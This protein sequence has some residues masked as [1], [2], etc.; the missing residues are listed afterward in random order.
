MVRWLR[1]LP[2]F[3]KLLI[4]FVTMI[5][6]VGA[7]GV[8]AIARELSARASAT[9]DADLHRASLDARGVLLA[10]ELYVLE[11]ANLAAN[12]QGM[13]PAVDARNQAET[14]RLLGTVLALKSDLDLV[15][16]TTADGVPLVTYLD[17][18]ARLAGERSENRAAFIDRALADP[19]AGRHAGFLNVAGRPMLAIAAP[20]CPVLD[21]CAPVGAAVVG[22][23]LDEL[24]LD[25]ADS[26]IGTGRDG[27]VALF[28]ADGQ[29]LARVGTTADAVSTAA[30]EARELVRRAETVGD[31]DVHTLYAPLN[32]QGQSRGTLAVSLPTAPVFDVVRGAA[33]RLVLV[34]LMALVGI[35]AVGALVSRWVLGQVR[36]LMRT[37]RAL[38]SGELSARAPVTS[39]DEI[40]QLAAGLN[41]MAEQLQASYRNL[42][43]RVEQRTQEVRRLLEERTQFFAS[44]S[45]ELRTPL[46]VILSESGILIEDGDGATQDSA[47]AIRQC[48]GQLTT[49]VNDILELA[50]AE[51]GNLR[52]EPRPVDVVGF[53]QGLQ[54]SINA[55]ASRG[56]VTATVTVPD[57]APP[58]SADPERLREIVLN[59]VDNAVKF[60]AADGEVNVSAHARGDMVDVLVA[61]TGTG[62]PPQVGQRLF[63]PFYQVE[64]TRPREGMSSSGLGLALT[65][66]LVQAHG[67][68]ISYTSE[69]GQGTTFVV[70]LPVHAHGPA[71]AP[72]PGSP[73]GHRDGHR[74]AAARAT[75]AARPTGTAQR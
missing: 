26:A 53:L 28:D 47:R 67:G 5:L 34:M 51:T 68:R 49:A 33:G 50:R 72:A 20:I 14:D 7:S 58:V 62:I 70:T 4:P 66:R 45:H 29:V 9:L 27:G 25:L 36:P 64:G 61:D 56:S 23:W 31:I 65:H 40:G 46:A 73:N 1:D 35:V 22:V 54:P 13:A 11:S 16:T 52:V 57:R 21:G 42:E 6:I 55:L 75:R 17:Q 43:S 3:W 8:F 19:T 48:A 44:L 10:R 24:A 41:R 60:T 37:N 39:T 59:L 30:L 15:M 12:L 32:V 69:P 74:P 63:E 18:A 71:T 2:L 38:G